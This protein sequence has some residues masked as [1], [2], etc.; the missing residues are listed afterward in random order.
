[1]LF[2]QLHF[3]L[4]QLLHTLLCCLSVQ[5]AQGKASSAEAADAEAPVATPH[6]ADSNGAKDNGQLAE[7]AKL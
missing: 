3:I 6:G 2:M 5:A 1:M 4:T 7:L